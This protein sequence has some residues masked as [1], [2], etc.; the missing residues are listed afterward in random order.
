MKDWQ[1]RMNE[2]IEQLQ[3]RKDSLEKWLCTGKSAVMAKI[4]EDC[5]NPELYYQFLTYQLEAM[6]SYLRELTQ[7]KLL[8]KE[9]E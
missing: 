9:A 7:Q 8:W 5:E 4:S 3:A 6:Y 1:I 2:E